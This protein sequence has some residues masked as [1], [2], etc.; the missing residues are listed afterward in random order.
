MKTFNKKHGGFT[1]VELVVVVAVVGVLAVVATPKIIGVANNARDAAL[2]GVAGA[3]TA[4]STRNYASR[5]ANNSAG[6]PVV[7]C[8][9]VANALEDGLPDGYQFNGGTVTAGQWS[10]GD[11][12]TAIAAEAKVTCTLSTTSTPVRS[13]PFTGIGIL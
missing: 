6:V 13:L 5:G 3:L 8:G 4:A 11:A 12:D 7:K 9:D 1:L 10:G 2:T